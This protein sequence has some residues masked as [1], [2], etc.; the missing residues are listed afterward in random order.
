MDQT[1][2]QRSAGRCPEP[3]GLRE[4]EL[5]A[6]QLRP[7]YTIDG[8]SHRRARWPETATA[9]CADCGARPG[10]YHVPGCF[11]ERC[12]ACDGDV[13]DCDCW[14]GTAPPA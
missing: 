14:Y 1:P 13:I 2:E 8:T 12:P 10:Q 6:A 9:P 3:G 7:T 11:E 5:E 4:A